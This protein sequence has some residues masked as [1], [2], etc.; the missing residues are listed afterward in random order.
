LR[1]HFTDLDRLVVGGVMPAAKPVELPN[2]KETGRA[3]FWNNASW[4]P[5]TSAARAR[6]LPTAKPFALDK[7]DCV[8]LPM[9][10][11]VSFL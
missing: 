9:G 5:S 7:L 2:H 10:T 1:G 8:Y 3:F 6:S 4:A 11:K